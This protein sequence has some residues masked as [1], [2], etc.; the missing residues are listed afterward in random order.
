MKVLILSCNT[1]GG[2][3]MAGRA[4]QEVLELAGHKT[5]FMDVMMLAG[6]KTSKVVSGAYI[7]LARHCPEVFGVIYK[8]GR[9]VSSKNRKSP[10]YYANYLLAKRLYYYITEHQYDAVIM[11]HLFPAE[12]V[13][14]IY[15]KVQREKMPL[16]IAIATD[17]ACIPFWEETNCDYYIIPNEEL[18]AEFVDAGVKNDKIR[19]YGIPVSPK[20]S[21]TYDK[22][23]L[24]ENAGIPENAV[25][26]LIAGGSMGYDKM[27]RF[28]LE[29]VEHMNEQEYAIVVCGN[30]KKMYEYLKENL[31][32][33]KNVQV[34]GYTSH[35][36]EY[37]A[38]SDVYYTKPGGVS[39]TEA[40]VRNIPLVF[41]SDIPGCETKN[42]EF[43]LSRGMASKADEA[44]EAITEGRRLHNIK[45][46]SNNMKGNQRK[47]INHKAAEDI[48]QFME[49][50]VYGS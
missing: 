39:S 44:L 6:E 36:S 12:I 11:P 37:L 16:T 28:S 3:N 19:A 46:A 47:Y 45:H 35:M 7:G 10:V 20:Y 33:R 27:N 18:R 48:M 23:L 21:D 32:E 43:F 26:Y 5:E 1:G 4:M 14:A 24:R 15:K 42:K 30:N 13:T 40:A 34:L 22:A 38:L 2:H 49:G 29:F 9:A 25:V 17:Y 31:S 50:E 41:L 8:A